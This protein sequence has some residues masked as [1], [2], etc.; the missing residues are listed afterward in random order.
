MR[1]GRSLLVLC[2]GG[3]GSGRRQAAERFCRGTQRALLVVRTPRLC[4][5]GPV[6]FAERLALLDQEG[7][8]RGAVLFWQDADAL[9]TTER[10]AH[11]D[12]LLDVIEGYPHP[13]FLAG[14]SDWDLPDLLGRR[15]VVRLRFSPPDA[16][17]RAAL[18]RAVLGG[19]ASKSGAAS[20]AGAASPLPDR[21]DLDLL[22][23]TFRFSAGQIRSAAEAARDLAAA[24]DPDRPVL[25]AEDL[26]EAC[27]ARAGHTLTTVARR[28][29]SRARWAD[30]VL[31][32]TQHRQLTEIADQIR[33]RGLVHDS[34]GFGDRLAGGRGLNVLFSGPPG[35]G[36]TMAAAVLANTV[37]VDLYAIDLSATVSKYIGET[38]K[39][40]ERIFA[41]ARDGSA[42]LFFDEADALFGRRSA[43]RD[44]HDRYAN[45]E[46]SY[47]LQ[48]LEDHD[49]TVVLAT[50][51]RKNM[52]DA[53]V[54]RLHATVDFP[55]PGEAE[56][57]RIWSGILPP[58]APRHQDVDLAALARDVELP[59]GN[60][61]NIALAG[62]FLAAADGGVITMAH[63]RA[64]TRSEY[65]SMGKLAIE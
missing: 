47:L 55:V 59:G 10:R 42:M 43:V 45:V 37:G 41:E 46:I 3:P 65:R 60:I 52:D 19:P 32:P 44:A 48:K 51:L 29:R 50:N 28:V 31:P 16:A 5:L 35:T 15:L 20:T 34:W 56:R 4:D 24:R 23:S 30:L 17:G 58:Q 12:V 18:W 14:G 62:A 22:A 7:R 27:R 6:E 21:L 61:R 25:T 2:C 1:T 11:L 64:A 9:G 49:G 53:F 54:R 13:V 36:K 8:L 40:L 63:L 26:H 33:L 38:E 57:L 39:N